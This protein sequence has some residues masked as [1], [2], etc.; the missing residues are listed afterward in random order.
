[1]PSSFKTGYV[2]YKSEARSVFKSCIRWLDYTNTVAAI[3]TSVR[4]SYFLSCHSAQ[5]TPVFV[6]APNVLEAVDVPGQGAG[7]AQASD[8]MRGWWNPDLVPGKAV[9]LEASLASLREVLK[10]DRFDVSNS[11][12]LSVHRLTRNNRVYLVSAKEQH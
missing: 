6:D 10:N 11:T 1:M 8:S 7:A 4:F 5:S 3:S 2:L 12:Y 9:G